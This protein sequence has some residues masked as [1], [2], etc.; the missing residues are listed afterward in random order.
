MEKLNVFR[1]EPKEYYLGDWDLSEAYNR[2]HREDFVNAYNAG[3]IE[4]VKEKYS[5][6]EFT[7][8]DEY[9]YVFKDRESK[10]VI[11]CANLVISKSHYVTRIEVKFIEAYGDGKGR[12]IIN[13]LLSRDRIVQLYGYSLESAVGFWKKVGAT[14]DEDS[15]FTLMRDNPLL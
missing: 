4:M 14:V 15:E 12:L 7:P 13:Y 1:R 5:P 3:T 10:E 2:I 8:L 6:N 9:F 11:G